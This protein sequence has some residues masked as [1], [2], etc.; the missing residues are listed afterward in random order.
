[1]VLAD[2]PTGNLDQG[3]AEQIYQLMLELNTEM[4]TAFV[5]VTHDLS[6]AERMDRIYH[7]QQGRLA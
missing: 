6:L 5:I 7:L 1:V 4:E 3:T 2:E